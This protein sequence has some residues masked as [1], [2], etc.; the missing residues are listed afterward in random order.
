MNMQIGYVT[1]YDASDIR[2]WSGSGHY[3]ARSLEQ[4][5]LS[6]DYFGPLNR[7]LKF[8]FLAKKLFFQTLFRQR[9]FVQIEPRILRSY[10]RQVERSLGSSS[11]IDVVFSPGTIPIAALES[12]K[13]IVF[14]SDAVFGGMLDFY[15]TF[16][17][18]TEASVRNGHEMETQALSRCRL[19][20][21]SSEWAANQAIEKYSA[22]KAKVKVVPFGA[23][24]NCDR[25][26]NDIKEVVA[27]RPTD[28]CRLLFN[29]VEW[30]RKGGD[31]ALE[32]ATRLKEQGLRVE[33]AIVG[34]KPPVKVPEF[35]TV[36]GFI[37]K[38]NSRGVRMLNELYARS[39]FL[40]L[41]SRAETFGV[42]FAEASSFGLPSI[43]RNVGGIPAAIRNDMNGWIFPVDADISEYCSYISNLMLNPKLYADLALRTFNEYETRL[44]WRVAGKAVKTLLAEFV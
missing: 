36:Y 30:F 27:R 42:V 18:L 22:D 26:W 28:R 38:R 33:L 34:C 14:W 11:H 39:H 12:E 5:G 7:D 17:G 4:Q 29:G 32:I 20:I 6:L 43:S 15:S 13:P 16:S 19:A 25:S 44:N 40:L 1:T 10:A 9:H 21:Y 35:V 2:N 24:I 8:L 23:N 31:I 3:I 37:S 41:P